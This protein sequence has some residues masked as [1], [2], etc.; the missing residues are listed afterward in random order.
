MTL[1]RIGEDGFH[2]GIPDEAAND[3]DSVVV[4]SD[5]V[6]L[7][8]EDAAHC[9]TVIPEDRLS[10]DFDVDDRLRRGQTSVEVP[11]DD[12]TELTPDDDDAVQHFS[13]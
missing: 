12:E 11:E 9:C 1:C 3:D 7:V 13:A 4:G 8:H 5:E 2:L 6:V 10:A